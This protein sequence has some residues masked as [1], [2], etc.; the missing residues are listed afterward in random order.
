MSIEVGQTYRNS[1]N[2]ELTIIAKVA[3]FAAS[4]FGM[5]LGVDACYR[6]QDC[7]SRTTHTTQALK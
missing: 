1:Q 3:C 4:R 5:Y 2:A 6:E 7:S